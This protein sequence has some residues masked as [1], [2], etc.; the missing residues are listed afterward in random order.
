[1]KLNDD[2]RKVMQAML[3]GKNVKVRIFP[4]YAWESL[5]V[6]HIQ[7]I[8]DG[9]TQYCIEEPAVKV[10]LFERHSR[11]ISITEDESKRM[12]DGWV[13]ISDWI[14]IVPNRDSK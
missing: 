12:L 2:Q 8:G 1:M 3:D 10:A 7:Y 5:V 14:E 9:E 13:R 11:V 4:E 6:S